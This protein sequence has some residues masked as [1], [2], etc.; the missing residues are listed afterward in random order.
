MKSRGLAGKTLCR[1]DSFTWIL[2]WFFSILSCFTE[3]ADSITP[4]LFKWNVAGFLWV[5]PFPSFL[6]SVAMLRP[7]I[8]DRPEVL[9]QYERMQLSALHAARRCDRKNGAFVLFSS[10]PDCDLGQAPWS[11]WGCFPCQKS[12]ANNTCLVSRLMTLKWD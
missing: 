5:P 3:V 11:G 10:V 8:T 7:E 4:W 12:E 6:I 1:I 2:T 9:C